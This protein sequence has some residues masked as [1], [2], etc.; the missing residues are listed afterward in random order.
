MQLINKILTGPGRGSSAGSLVAFAL[1]ITDV[2]PLR[3]GLIFERFLNPER[4]TMPDIDIDFA[5]NR[6]EE[7]IQYV[8]EKYGKSYVAQ[9]ITFGTLSARAVARNVARVFGFSN[10]EM[11]FISKEIPSR[12][13]ITLSEAIEESKRLRD[14]ISH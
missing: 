14:W 9:I 6:R 5:D 10:E 13:G 3:Y 11:G 1:G 7:V 12:L 4:V 8:A 2:D